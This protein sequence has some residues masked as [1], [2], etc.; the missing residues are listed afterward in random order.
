MEPISTSNPASAEFAPSLVDRIKRIV[1]TFGVFFD[2]N[3]YKKEIVRY[4]SELQ[5]KDR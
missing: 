2:V 3:A 1:T 4:E 5:H